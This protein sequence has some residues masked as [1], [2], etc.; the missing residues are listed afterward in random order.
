MWADTGEQ[1]SCHVSFSCAWQQMHPATSAIHRCRK[2]T[3]NKPNR[4][5]DYIWWQQTLTVWKGLCLVVNVSD[6][7]LTEMWIVWA[8]IWLEMWST[9]V[10]VL[11]LN[12][13]DPNWS[14]ARK[15]LSLLV[16]WAVRS[17]LWA[18]ITLSQEWLHWNEWKTLK[19]QKQI[20]TFIALIC[21]TIF[22]LIY[23]PLTYAFY[24]STSLKL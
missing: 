1:C 20:L 15:R 4:T 10:A 18:Y 17:E 12:N 14:S 23:L 13:C 21:T 16:L 7:V 5:W 3:T 11:D 24:P 19:K 8:E 2:K 9:Q 6:F 22:P